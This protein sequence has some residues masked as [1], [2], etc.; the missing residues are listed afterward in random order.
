MWLPVLFREKIP[1]KFL[2]EFSGSTIFGTVNTFVFTYS[3]LTN[4]LQIAESVKDADKKKLNF[5]FIANFF[6]QFLIVSGIG[7]CGYLSI[8]K[9]QHEGKPLPSLI[10]YRTLTDPAETDYLMTIGKYL[11]FICLLVNT[12]INLSPLKSWIA[13]LI[14]LKAGF[15]YNLLLS[16]GI[17]SLLGI[18]A[19]TLNDINFIMNVAGG[20]FGIPMIFVFPALIAIKK[21]LFKNTVAHVFLILW[22]VFWIVFTIYTIYD[23]IHGKITGP[24]K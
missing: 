7:I 21:R 8:A 23:I 14:N 24:K 2:G 9:L 20:V 18:L 4:F 10:I 16:L 17:V 15:V 5:V 11:L 12:G 13:E 6:M 19:Y 1:L 22:L 3:C